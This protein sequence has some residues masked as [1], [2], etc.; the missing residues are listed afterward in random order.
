MKIITISKEI[1]AN[2]Q[3]RKVEVEGHQLV[4]SQSHLISLL[5]SL[6]SALRLTLLVKGNWRESQ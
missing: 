1:L 4:S 5:L 2:L 6:T 3:G